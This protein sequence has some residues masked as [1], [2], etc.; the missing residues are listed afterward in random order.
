MEQAEVGDPL[1]PLVKRFLGDR[2]FAAG[3]HNDAVAKWKEGLALNPHAVQFHYRIALVHFVNGDYEP[4]LQELDQEPLDGFRVEGRAI[5]LFAMGE[6]EKADAEL[7]LLI[8]MGMRWTYEI[9]AVHAYRGELDEAFEWLDH[10]IAR[11]DQ[12]LPR[13]QHD[14]YMKNLYDDPRFDPLLERLGQTRI[15]GL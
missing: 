1:D 3:R 13:L 8:D 15:P 12:S 14:P 2:Y 5:T 7:A 11:R 10:A 6:A 4:A 9:A